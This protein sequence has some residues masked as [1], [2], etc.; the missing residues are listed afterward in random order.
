MKPVVRPLVLKQDYAEVILT[1]GYTAAI[2]LDD[3]PL[4]QNYNWYAKPEFRKDGTL[5][6]VYA[7][8]NVLIQPKH[9]KTVLMHTVILKCNQG[10]VVD[11][12][13]GWGLNNRK[14][15]L[16]EATR[17]QNMHNQGVRVNNKTGF[18]GVSFHS[19]LQKYVAKICINGLVRHLGYFSSKE[20]AAEVY[21][22]ACYT[23]HGTFAKLK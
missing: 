17:S 8:R 9:R 21:K 23:L 16:R 22:S 10:F 1:R 11:H 2:D 19:P 4:I 12:L 15:N 20:E 13:D 18:K 7:A 14:N 5:E 6:V 3:V